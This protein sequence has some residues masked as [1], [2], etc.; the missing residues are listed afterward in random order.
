MKLKP[1]LLAGVLALAV[2]GH[3]SGAGNDQADIAG[4]RY[5]AL[6]G[7]ISPLG[8]EH[9]D[10]ARLAAEVLATE[11]GIAISAIQ[12]DTVRAVEWRDSSIGCPQPGVGYLQV[13]TPGHEITLRVGD[14]MHTIHEANRRAFLCKVN[15]QPGKATGQ[16]NLVWGTQGI[17]ARRDL[18]ARLG[19][20]EETITIAGA[21]ER[22]FADA[23][24]ECPEPGIDYP[25]APRDGFV[26]RLSHDS[27]DYTYHTDM[28][29]TVMCPPSGDD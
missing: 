16:P 27:R 3:A 21:T 8:G 9:R 20:D 7:K 6:D 11:L 19:V 10:V 2:I 22:R 18:A 28:E 12:V 1:C 29:R 13:I 5:I 4:A 23:S 14:R 15:Q 25:E 24:L 17:V 26:L